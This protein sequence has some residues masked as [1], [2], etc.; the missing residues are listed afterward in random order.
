M[1][2]N[3]TRFVDASPV[4]FAYAPPMNSPEQA[5]EDAG[6][7]ERC[8]GRIAATHMLTRTY[9]LDARGRWRRQLHEFSEDVVVVCTRCGAE[10]D[11]TFDACDGEFAFI[12]AR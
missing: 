10:P 8:G 11:G 6:R 7:C 9:T 12:P 2:P 5:P 1:R 3:I 4:V